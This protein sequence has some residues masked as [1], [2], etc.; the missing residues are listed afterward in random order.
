MD[1]E[2]YLIQRAGELSNKIILL[3]DELHHCQEDRELAVREL[4]EIRANRPPVME[5]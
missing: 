4:V 2:Q 5:G 1:R 3:T